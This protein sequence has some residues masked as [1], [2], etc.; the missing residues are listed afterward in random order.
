MKDGPSVPIKGALA[1]LKTQGEWAAADGPFGEPEPTDHRVFVWNMSTDQTI[2][3]PHRPGN[4]FQR[5]LAVTPTE[6][7]LAESGTSDPA[8]LIKH[9]VRIEFS[10]LANLA[11]A[12]AK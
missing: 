4:V 10:K 8:Q 1:D 3:L 2:T 9:V 12:W 6:L 11:A 5:V 7:V